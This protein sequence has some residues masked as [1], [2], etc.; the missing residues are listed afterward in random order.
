MDGMLRRTTLALGAMALLVSGTVSAQAAGSGEGL[1]FMAGFGLGYGTGGVHA[2]TGD[3]KPGS[4]LLGRVGLAR[5]GRPFVVMD[6][7]WQLYKAPMPTREDDDCNETSGQDCSATQFGAFSVLVGVNLYVAENFYL[8]P[9]VGAQFRDV[10]GFRSEEYSTT[11]FAAG[12][13]A[14]YLL[15]FGETFTLSPELYLRYATMTGP[16]APSFRSIG[17]RLV[18]AWTF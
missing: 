18:A 13:N 2:G 8:Q 1:R 15:P 11:G 16:N 9:Q 12:L 17:F 10:A 5:D 6:G 4:T 14:G 3:S 7:E